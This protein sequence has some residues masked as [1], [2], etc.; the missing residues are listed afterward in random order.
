MKLNR[1]AEL[2]AKSDDKK[3][4]DTYGNINGIYDGGEIVLNDFESGIFPLK[5]TERIE[6]IAYT[7]KQI[8]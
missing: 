3:K 8:F 1:T 7:S 4:I 2:K 6:I 5:P